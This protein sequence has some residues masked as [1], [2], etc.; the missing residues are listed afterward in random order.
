M[1]GVDDS[2]TVLTL[3]SAETP[4]TSYSFAD[5]AARLDVVHVRHRRP[6]FGRDERHHAD[7]FRRQDADDGVRLTVDANRLTDHRWTGAVLA[8]PRTVRDDGHARRARLVVAGHERAADS[9]LHA[10]DLKVIAGDHLTHREPRAI[11]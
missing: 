2:P 1:Y 10:E 6:D 7:E 11:G 5:D 3:Q 4:T 8:I 9:R